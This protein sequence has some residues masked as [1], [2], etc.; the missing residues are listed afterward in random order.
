MIYRFIA[1]SVL[2][3]ISFH[4][5]GQSVTGIVRFKPDNSLAPGVNV[6]E[7]GTQNGTVTDVDGK[8]SLNVSTLDATLVTSFIGC[9]TT[10]VPLQGRDYVEI[11]L[12]VDCIRDFFDAQK[13][14][15]YASSGLVHTPAGLRIELTGPAFYKDLNLKAAVGYQTNF[16]GNEFLNLQ[17]GLDHLFLSCNYD[18]DLLF[19]YNKVKWKE[20][21]D[22]TSKSIQTNLNFA[23]KGGL[24]LLLG[25]SA[26]S[27]NDLE[28]GTH[29]QR[30]GP[31][32]GLGKWIG[33]PINTNITVK[34]SI[35]NGLAEYN[36]ELR[37]RLKRRINVFA[38]YYKVEAFT[39][40]S[41]G[42]GWQATY[43]FPWQRRPRR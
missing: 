28:S 26:I 24:S 5:I 38:R 3:L 14:G 37:K 22:M 4:G 17:A 8:F 19:N 7:L 21:V 41:L 1:L 29:Q 30:S 13:F 25:Y 2:L 42:L 11:A 35:Y 32:V 36:A 34:A 31:L 33:R 20:H 10:E 16:N 43:Y 40:V 6:V 23:S 9:V 39:E 12:K 18:Q 27:F 15:L